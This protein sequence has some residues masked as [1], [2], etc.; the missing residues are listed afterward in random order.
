YKNNRVPPD[1][2]ILITS[3]LVQQ[4]RLSSLPARDIPLFDGDPLQSIAFMKAFEQGVE[5]KASQGDC[6]Y[7]LEQFTRGQPRELIRSCLH[8]T[9]EYGYAKAKQLLCEHFG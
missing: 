1:G 9:P 4:Q 5:Q 7:Y 6:L 3:A 2:G 8:M